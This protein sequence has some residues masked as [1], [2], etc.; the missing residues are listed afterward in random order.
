MSEYGSDH[1]REEESLSNVRAQARAAGQGAEAECHPPRGGRRRSAACCLPT[2]TAA[3]HGTALVHGWQQ[4]ARPAG[5]AAG[6]RRQAGRW[7]LRSPHVLFL[8]TMPLLFV[9]FANAARCRD[10]VQGCRQDHQRCAAAALR[11]AHGTRLLPCVARHG[12]MASAGDACCM[13]GCLLHAPLLRLPLA[14]G[15]VA[16]MHS[17]MECPDSLVWALSHAAARPHCRLASSGACGG[18]S[19]TPPAAPSPARRAPLQPR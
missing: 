7:P 3:A 12:G 13:G 4:R 2:A 9:S 5:A 1:E 11:A 15:G 19:P 16:S 18:G 14:V 6:R 17:S 8:R 10:Q